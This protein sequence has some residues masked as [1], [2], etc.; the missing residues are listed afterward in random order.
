MSS[1]RE[2][3]TVDLRGLRAALAAR[4]A[5]RGITQADVLRAALASDLK[6]DDQPFE[7]TADDMTAVRPPPRRLEKLSIRLTGRSAERMRQDAR[8][9]GLSRGAYLSSLIDGA[10]PLV[11]SSER[12]EA[13]AALKLSCAELA[14]L[15]RDVRNLNRLLRGGSV[16]AAGVYRGRF[17]TTD[18]EVRA[19]LQRAATVLAMLVP[20]RAG[21]DRP[22]SESRSLRRKR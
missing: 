19:H 3:F 1:A 14:V 10:P 18:D 2:F 4:A 21:N 11:P 13:I 16:D 9:A 8:A 20:H 12:A 17:D 7:L 15:S 5:E 22:S 6:V